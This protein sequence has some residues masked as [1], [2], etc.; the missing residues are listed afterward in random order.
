MAGYILHYYNIIDRS[1]VDE[2]GPMSLPGVEKCGGEII[3][4]SPVKMLKDKTTYS[5]MIIY[6][7]ESFETAL[8]CYNLESEEFRKFRDQIVDVITMVLPGHSA[9]KSVISSGYFQG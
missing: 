6:K 5:N 2:L 4:A 1:R 8:E 7:F 3:V 9:T